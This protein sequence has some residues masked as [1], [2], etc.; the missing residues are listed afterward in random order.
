MS[1]RSHTLKMWIALVGC[2]FLI[3]ALTACD[4]G[5]AGAGITPR[6]VTVLVVCTTCDIRSQVAGRITAN[7][8]DLLRNNCSIQSSYGQI[9][10]VC[11]QIP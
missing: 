1:R 4:D 8:R 10:I 3:T 5:Q 7:S 9:A 6:N 2:V 11:P